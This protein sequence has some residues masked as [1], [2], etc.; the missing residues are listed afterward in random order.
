MKRAVKKKSIF[1]KIIRALLLA[2]TLL[3]TAFVLFFAVKILSLDA[4]RTFD[5]SKILGVPQTL[6][7]YDENG[8]ELTRLDAG[9]DRV[10]V[11][12]D[13][14]PLHLQQA[15]ISAEDNR[16]YE[17]PGI[18]IIRIFGAAWQDIKAGSYVQGAST[19]TQQLIKWTH[20]STEKT[21]SRKLEEAVLAYQ[22]EQQFTKAE[23]LEMYLNY[24]NFGRGYYGVEAAAM[25]YFGVHASELTLAQG[26]TLAGILKA[27][28]RYSPHIAPE[29]SRNR[30][31][32]VITLMCNYGYIDEATR[33]A[34]CAE[35]LTIVAETQQKRGYYVNAA[36][37]EAAGVLGCDIETLLTKGYRI[38]TCADAALQTRC[39]DLFREGELFP[40]EDCEGALA[41]VRVSDSSVAALVGGRSVDAAAAFNRAT[42]IRRQPGSV[43]K[44]IIVYGPALEVG[45]YTAASSMLDERTDFS[46]YSPR[47]FADKYYGWV[48][49][50]E[51][52]KRSLNVPAVKLMNDIGVDRC[53]AFAS[54][55]GV[56]FDEEDNSLTLALGGF[57]YGVSPLQMAGAYAAFSAGGTY[58]APYLV[59]AI[60][61]NAGNVVYSHY[62]ER[63]RVMSEQ[64]AYILT[65]MLQS[66]ISEG[67]GKRLGALNLG[68]AGK[69]GTVG[70]G[71]GNRDAWM[72]AYSPDYSACMWMGYDS[73]A[74]GALP[75]EATGGNY[76]ALMLS[77]VYTYLYPEL[78]RREFSV[79]EG[80]VEIRLDGYTMKNSHAAVLANAFTPSESVVTEVF[81]VGTEP[82]AVTS[83]WAVPAAA[84]NFSVMLSERGQPLIS[85]IASQETTVYK[86]YRIDKDGLTQLVKQWS[87]KFGRVSYEDT[88]AFFGTYTYYVIP[89]HPELVINGKKVTGPSTTRVP[90]TVFSFS[91]L[92]PS[93]GQEIELEDSE[94]D[95]GAA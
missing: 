92:W 56:E 16:Y 26:A 40:S 44:P 62:N 55:L 37:E 75:S 53:K 82:D 13:Q 47:N 31:N 61:D 95:D 18:D 72:A 46:G 63:V 2:A 65:S 8:T 80:I 52:V 33:D 6:I 17:H 93:A 90:I 41:V 29:A 15:V 49:L 9:E 50:R 10:W 34:A 5:A 48:M 91:Q 58:E 11:P 24:N 81:A 25:G 35:P 59:R 60:T 94:F 77:E 69:T 85:F 42:D 3:V 43:I 66:A 84:R 38:Y 54:M 71:D 20:L 32:L 21:M 23:I 74:D 27:P 88:E 7:I 1:G 4:W 14:I 86:L 22:M 64:N 79:P 12:L 76:P 39:E 51:A 89:E 67:T 68:L 19:I 30:R 73:S 36:L 28:A 87:G 83:Y 78:Q 57:A 70:E 45:G